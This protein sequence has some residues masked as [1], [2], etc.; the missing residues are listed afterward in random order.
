M[1]SIVSA[2]GSAI[3]AIISAIANVIETI[4][5]AIVMILVAI[6]D[7][8][9]SVDAADSEDAESERVTEPSTSN[10]SDLIPLITPAP[11]PFH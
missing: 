2:I 3:N 1:G 4:I 8:F 7:F 6:W 5:S 11:E 10:S 9:L